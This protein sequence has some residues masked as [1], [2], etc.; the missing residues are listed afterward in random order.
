MK[1]LIL[2]LGLPLSGKT[3]YYEKHLKNR[4]EKFAYINADDIKFEFPGYDETVEGMYSSEAIAIARERVLELMNIHGVNVIM[5]AGGINGNY[6]I[7]IMEIA[8]SLGYHIEMIH[9]DTPYYVCLERN[10]QRARSVPD[11]MILE[12][13]V[14]RQYTWGRY[15]NSGLL[16][17]ATVVPYFTEKHLFFDMDGVLASFSAL[18]V[19]EGK[20]DYVNSNF[21]RYLPVVPQVRDIINRLMVSSDKPRE[22]Y[23]LSAAPTSISLEEKK[24]WLADNFPMLNPDNFYFVNSGR[25]K[26][27]MFHDLSKRL[28]LDKRDMCLI[29][30]T[31]QII[32]TVR[33]D[34]KMHS[35]HIS[36]FL[37]KYAY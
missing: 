29:E 21:Y 23:I 32:D 9:M 28:K 34:Y 20:I 17:K 10:K 11:S 36:E 19:V 2:F 7:G 30:D 14:K 5:D 1:K 16:D 22:F 31:K 6:T 12:K 27:E 25:Y 33:E 18:P 26:A 4:D 24:L 8:K 3:S 13:E 15:L 35:I 37:T